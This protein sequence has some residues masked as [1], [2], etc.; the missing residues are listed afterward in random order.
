MSTTLASPPASPAAPPPA[1]RTSGRVVAILAILLGVVLIAGVALSAVLSTTRSFATRTATLTADTAGLTALD[2]DLSAGDLTITY[3]DVDEATLTVTG[4][5][6]ADWRLTRAGDELKLSTTRSWWG[7]WGP[8]DLQNDSAVLT[9]PTGT[10]ALDA[11]LE[12]SAGSI[13]ADGDFRELELD[14]SA[15]SID[16]AGAAERI[17]VSVSA[18]DASFDLDGVRTGTLETS[19]GRIDGE[20]RGD[21]PDRLAIEV[22]AGEIRLRL[23]DE[24]YDVTADVSAG[25]LDNRL[26][27]ARGAAHTI[28]VEVSAGSVVLIP[29]QG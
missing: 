17:D 16:V 1:P 29:G 9:L 3:G 24:T 15:G 4:S 28:S 27:T 20:L 19:A 21:A 6:A 5:G 12:L 8:F 22:S 26:A 18:G 23:P 25:S 14:L 7:G 13:T 10:G 2:V 11:S